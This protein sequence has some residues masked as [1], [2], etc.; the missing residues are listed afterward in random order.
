MNK[1]LNYLSVFPIL[2]LSACSNIETSDTNDSNGTQA[3]KFGEPFIA[4]AITRS[5]T[6]DIANADGLKAF[7]AKIWGEMYESNTYNASSAS[8]AFDN[9]EYKILKWKNDTEGW[10]YDD[11]VFWNPDKNYD[12]VGFAPADESNVATY[13]NGLIQLQDIPVVQTIDNS[14]NSKK[15]IDYLLSDVATSPKSTSNRETIGLVFRHLLSRLSIYVWKDNTLR[16]DILLKDLTLFL[17]NSEAKATYQEANHYGPQSGVD[18]WTWHGHTDIPNATNSTELNTYSSFV[19]NNSDVTVPTCGD[20][21]MAEID[22]KRMNTEFFIAPTPVDEDVTIYVKATYDLI[23]ENSTTEITKFSKLSGL[24]TLKQ[25]YKHNVYICIG[26]QALA[27]S[28][29]KVESWNTDSQLEQSIDNLSGHSYGFTAWQKDFDIAGIIKVTDYEDISFG[30][31]KLRHKNSGAVS[32]AETIIDG[33]FETADCS[34]TRWDEP[35]YNARFAKFRVTP[36]PKDLPD[37]GTYVLTLS[38][39]DGDENSSDVDISMSEMSFTVEATETDKKFTI[40]LATGTVPCSIAFVWGDDKPSTLVY[41]TIQATDCVH[42][43]QT[44]GTYRIRIISTQTD[45]TRQQIPEFNFGKYPT[46]TLDISDYLKPAYDPNTNGQ[47][48]RSIE[49]PV[50]YTGMDDLSTMFYGTGVTSICPEIFKYYK[51]AKKLDATFTNCSSLTE[52]PEEIFAGMDD[53][54]SLYSTFRG[55]SRLS[56]VPTSLINNMTKVKNMQACFRECGSITSFPDGFFANQPLCNNYRQLL[57][58][59]TNLKLQSNLF[60]D[61]S[62]GIT[63]ANRFTQCNTLIRIDNMFSGAGKLRE[64]DFGVVP[65]LW[66]YSYTN[67]YGFYKTYFP[68]AYSIEYENKNDIPDYWHNIEANFPEDCVLL[69]TE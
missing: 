16:Q 60:I 55:C 66:N 50:L 54:E 36:D 23:D 20:A 30:T 19:L 47:K 63:K 45:S 64:T 17:P 57:A 14:D 13:E 65:D 52:L 33:W 51:G 56:S 44:A 27:F 3:I 68:I 46:A 48:L 12:F 32:E 35:S 41:N 7:G 61:E 4:N 58:N 34:G 28:I 6:G 59:C 37:S 43:Y 42:T 21:L 11:I 5:A 53:V 31:A 38:D 62:K 18:S 9:D 22:A 26:D 10:T 2:V 25:G 69:Q 40:P 29:D 24:N 67:Q 39:Q 1:I 15:G 49:T 8:N